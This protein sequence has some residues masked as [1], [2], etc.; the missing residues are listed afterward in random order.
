MIS[1]FD[2]FYRHHGPVITI[3]VNSNTA[4]ACGIVFT[5]ITLMVPPHPASS[6]KRTTSTVKSG[7]NTDP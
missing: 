3:G 1:A 7:R 4:K 2:Y 6:G 5:I